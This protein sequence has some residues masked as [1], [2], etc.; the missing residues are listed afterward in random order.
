M[1]SSWDDSFDDCFLD[2]YLDNLDYFGNDFSLKPEQKE[3]IFS[4]ISGKNTVAVLPT[5]N[6]QFYTIYINTKKLL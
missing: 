4:L 3:A 2:I 1:G 6:I 5:G